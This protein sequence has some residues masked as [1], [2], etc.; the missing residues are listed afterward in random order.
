MAQNGQDWDPI[1]AAGVKLLGEDS[2]FGLR[3]TISVPRVAAAASINR[4]TLWR[5][6]QRD[7]TAATAGSELEPASDALVRLIAERV[8]GFHLDDAF[9]RIDELTGLYAAAL[10]AGAEPEDLLRMGFRMMFLETFEEYGPIPGLLIHAAAGTSGDALPDVQ[11]ANGADRALAD[12]LRDIVGRYYDDLTAAQDPLVRFALREMKREPRPGVTVTDIC[13]ALQ[14][15]HDGLA[16]RRLIHPTKVSVDFAAEAMLQLALSLTQ[17][18]RGAD[19]E[20]AGVDEPNSKGTRAI[21]LNQNLG[22]EAAE[23]RADL[24]EPGSDPVSRA[25]LGDA[26]LRSLLGDLPSALAAL[27]MRSPQPFVPRVLEWVSEIARLDPKLMVDALDHLAI[28]E[29]NS[30]L[31]ELRSSIRSALEAAGAP[32]DRAER[33]AH[34]MVEAAAQADDAVV[35]ALVDASLTR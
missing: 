10:N 9:R 1:Q 21:S 19:P 27:A 26:T 32:S 34:R 23:D 29:D 18:E 4:Q 31:G 35:G 17:E 22:L 3:S 8:C 16:N 28:A 15:L 30:V 2:I 5:Q 24:T 7:G 14:G 33:V 12:A 11:I 25:A 13:I 6:L 20:D